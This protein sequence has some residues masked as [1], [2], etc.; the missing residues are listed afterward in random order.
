MS[1]H[2]HNSV[3]AL[4]GTLGACVASTNNDIK[5]SLT[6][7]ASENTHTIQ[8]FHCLLAVPRCLSPHFLLSSGIVQCYDLLT[9]Q[10]TSFDKSTPRSLEKWLSTLQY[11]LLL[12]DLGLSPSTRWW[13][14]SIP[15]S[16]SRHSDTF[17]WLFPFSSDLSTDTSTYIADMHMCRQNTQTYKIEQI[18]FLKDKSTPC[19]WFMKIMYTELS[20][21]MLTIVK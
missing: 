14:T 4:K 15:N 2:S 11:L 19:L 6:L 8:S 10:V 18:E 9:M 16:S 3:K 21:Q 13:P 20:E 7:S 1:E 5:L 17:F 12:E